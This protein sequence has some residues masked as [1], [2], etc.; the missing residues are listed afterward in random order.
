MSDN[1]LLSAISNMMD[2]KML[3]VSSMMDQKLKAGL[4]PMENRLDRMENKMQTMQNEMQVMQND[5]QTI[6]ND[7]QT[8]HCEMQTMHNEMRGI[9]LFQENVILPR[10]STIESCYTD[11][12]DRYRDYADKMDAVITENEL[13]KKVVTEHS[14]QIQKLA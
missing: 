8:I 5:M 1:E 6:Q 13:L 12:Y 7:M 4:K 14:E 3:E 2:Q 9:R 10:L 11:T